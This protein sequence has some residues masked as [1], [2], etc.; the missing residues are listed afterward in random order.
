ME[1]LKLKKN[2]SEMILFTKY[3]PDRQNVEYQNVST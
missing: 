3:Y 2:I 1:D